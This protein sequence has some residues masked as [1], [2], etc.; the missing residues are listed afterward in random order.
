MAAT[1]GKRREIVLLD[2]PQEILE[3]VLCRLPLDVIRRCLRLSK[4]I[5]SLIT[6]FSFYERWIG[7]N[8][9]PELFLFSHHLHQENSTKSNCGR[10]SQLPS[11][12]RLQTTTGIIPFPAWVGEG[13]GAR[14]LP[15]VKV[16]AGRVYVYCAAT[17]DGGD[18]NPVVVWSLGEDGSWDFQAQFDLVEDFLGEGDVIDEDYRPDVIDS[19]TEVVAVTPEQE[20]L[21]VYTSEDRLMGFDP[22]TQ[23]YFYFGE[24]DNIIILRRSMIWIIRSCPSYALHLT[25]LHSYGHTQ[26]LQGRI[27]D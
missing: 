3:E 18:D 17:G 27:I 10:K 21:L 13:A 11:S 5:Y 8:L 2:L 25:T 15:T 9:R 7:A 24:H 19:F 22:N 1:Q 6:S 4:R 12:P 23:A 16:L 26:D 20:R 14:N